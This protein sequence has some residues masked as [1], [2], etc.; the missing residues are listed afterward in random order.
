MVDLRVDMVWTTGK[1]DSKDV[2]FI[3]ISK[4]F[5]A[6]F[7]DIG[8]YFFCFFICSTDSRCDLIGCNIVVFFHFTIHTIDKSLF[9]IQCD[10]RTDKGDLVIL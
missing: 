6:F 2:V 7:T 10:E 4:S 5:F 1:D 3:D 8:L 9:I